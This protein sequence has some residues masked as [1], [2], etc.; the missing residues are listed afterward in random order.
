VGG[1]HQLQR[2]LAAAH[3]DESLVDVAS[4][5]A[6]VSNCGGRVCSS[7]VDADTRDLSLP[8]CCHEKAQHRRMLGA[9]GLGISLSDTRN[10]RSRMS[11]DSASAARSLI[12]YGQLYLCR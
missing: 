4:C 12:P 8:L 11:A 1:L 7:R 9:L 10:I 6:D 2:D 5:S 3:V